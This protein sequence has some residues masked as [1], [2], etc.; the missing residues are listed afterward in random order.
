M[1]LVIHELEVLVLISEN[2]RRTAADQQL[3]QRERRARQLQVRL[4]KMI[5]VQV[6]VA[7]GPDELARLEIALLREQVRE[8]RVAGDVE[9]YAEK[10]IRAALVELAG[11]ASGGH[12]E[13]EKRMAGH[14]PHALELTHV[15]GADHDAARIRIGLE[16]L[17]GLGD[18]VDGA[19]VGCRPGAPLAAVDRA[20][21]AV[22]IRPFVPDRDAMLAQSGDVGVAAPDTQQ[23]RHHGAH[24][25]LLGGDQREAAGEIEVHLV[26]KHR[27]GAGAGAVILAHALGP[28]PAHQLQVLFHGAMAKLPE[29]ARTRY[30]HSSSATPP[31]IIGADSSCPS[32]NQPPAR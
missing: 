22:R 24:V 8:Q 20:Q 15:P 21:L 3:R 11:Q 27:Q 16:P 5:Q 4:L 14:E 26:A 13:L 19:S 12:V 32:L 28:D 23:L 7:A 30:A 25:D 10:R 1:M 17:D 2:A 18:L 29:G 31:T 9:W 6:A